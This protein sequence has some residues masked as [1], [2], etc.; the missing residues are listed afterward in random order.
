MERAAG[1]V[2]LFV[3]YHAGLCFVVDKIRSET[4]NQ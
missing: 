4:D 3:N 2:D 1:G